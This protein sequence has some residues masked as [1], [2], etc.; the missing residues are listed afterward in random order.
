MIFWL[1]TVCTKCALGVELHLN[2]TD[3]PV[4]LVSI[5]DCGCFA[6]DFDDALICAT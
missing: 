4:Q 1:V 5:F 3:T 2:T 6:Y